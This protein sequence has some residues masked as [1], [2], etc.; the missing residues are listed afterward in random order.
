MMTFSN[1]YA[2]RLQTLSE[3][4]NYQD[5][6]VYSVPGEFDYQGLLQGKCDELDKFLEDFNKKYKKNGNREQKYGRD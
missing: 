4:G 3:C 2:V 5:Y 1:D 6:Y